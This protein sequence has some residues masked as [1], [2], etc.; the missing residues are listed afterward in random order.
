MG[1]WDDK[2]TK[3]TMKDRY[4]RNGAPYWIV[5]FIA[6]G[7]ADGPAM[8]NFLTYTYDC[9]DNYSPFG[10]DVMLHGEI[11]EVKTTS[12]WKNGGG[13]WQHI[14]PGHEQWTVLLLVR[15]EYHSIDI[16]LMCRDEF[17]R[18]QRDG[19]ATSQ[20][21]KAGDS[22]EGYWFNPW[23]KALEYATLVE[24]ITEDPDEGDGD[25]EAMEFALDECQ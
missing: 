2:E 18:A 23:D 24:S 10:A 6:S 12:I 7:N 21:N 11:A 16:Y 9:I 25:C 14:E 19:A 3:E 8:E 20:G 13:V 17:E 5:N 22:F 15:I 1:F 4:I